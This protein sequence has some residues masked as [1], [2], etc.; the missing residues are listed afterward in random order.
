MTTRDI[1]ELREQA[2]RLRLHIVRMM[3]ADK[4]HHFGGSMSAADIVTALYFYAMR[5][6]PADAEWPERDRFI[7]SKGHCVPAQYAA[8]AML[9]VFPLD[10][11]PTLK[12]MGADYKDTRRPISCPA[13]RDARGRWGRGCRSPTEWHWPDVYRATI[14]AFTA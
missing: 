10:E 12:Q 14:I 6:D 8:L 5:F 1:R 3:G 7:M 2:A 11:L 13:S 4:A 9:G